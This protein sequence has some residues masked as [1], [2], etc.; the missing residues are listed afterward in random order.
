MKRHVFA[1]VVAVL[2]VVLPAKD[3]IRASTSSYTVEDL[4]TFEG[5][6]PTITG[7]N[8]SGQVSGWTR[9]GTIRR[10]VRYTNDLGW[11][12]IPGL[13][14]TNSTATAINARGDVAGFHGTPSRPFRYSDTSGVTTLDVLPGG[15]FAMGLAINA[16]GVMTGNGDSSSGLQRSWRSVPG[17]PSEIY[18]ELLP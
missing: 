3:I 17:E 15:S 1:V 13:H 9:S 10:A 11:Q 16:A 5:I 4:G 8:A 7:M 12:A 2:F 14:A 18:P 6:V